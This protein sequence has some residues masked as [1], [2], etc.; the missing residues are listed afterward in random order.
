MVQHSATGQDLS[1][2]A[3][4]ISYLLGLRGPSLALNTA[5][6]S[7]LV[8]V[9]LACQSLLSGESRLALAG[10]V[11]L[12]LSP[13]SSI[14][15]TKFGAMS[16][17]G[18]CRTFSAAADGYVRGEGAGLV[19]LARPVPC[20]GDGLSGCGPHPRHG[21]QQRRHEQRP[22]RAQRRRPAARPARRP[23]PRRRTP[24]RRRLR[25]GPRH[26]HHPGRPDRM[27]GPGRRIRPGSRARRPAAPGLRQDEHRPSRGRRRHRRPDQGAARAARRAHPAQPARGAP[28]ST[29]RLRAA[30]PARAARAGRMAH[31][32]R[33]APG[34]REL[35]RLRRHERPCGAR[36]T[37]R[38]GR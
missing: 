8:A 27:R 19:L 38:L 4:R 33:P 26:R 29:D 9:H 24:G 2:V 30:R 11:N 14:A 37:A 20:P 18:R 23:R 28:Q 35:F 5:C 15:M 17:T 3:A 16:P 12:M 7:S 22:R 1:I 34:R 10:G 21:G 13:D 36:G 32:P 6:S 31:A 25:R